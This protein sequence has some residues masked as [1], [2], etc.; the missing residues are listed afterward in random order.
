MVYMVLRDGSS[1]CNGSSNFSSRVAIDLIKV[2]IWNKEP[3]MRFQMYLL[4]DSHIC[5]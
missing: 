1:D 4:E 3:L 2:V 5:M